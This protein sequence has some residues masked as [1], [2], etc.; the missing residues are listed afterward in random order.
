MVLTVEPGLYFI[1]EFLNKAFDDPDVKG[2]FNKDKI[3]EYM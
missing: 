1:E 3:G 2:F